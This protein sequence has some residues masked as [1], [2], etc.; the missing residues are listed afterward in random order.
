MTLGDGERSEDNDEMKELYNRPD[1]IN[2]RTSAGRL[3]LNEGLR[4]ASPSR[5]FAAKGNPSPK[6]RTGE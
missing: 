6:G 1:G 4:K 3:D 2:C 5:P